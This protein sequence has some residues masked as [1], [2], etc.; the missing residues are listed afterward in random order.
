[1]QSP[2]LRKQPDISPDLRIRLTDAP[3]SFTVAFV[4]SRTSCGLKVLPS[5]VGVSRRPRARP[6]ER[7][8]SEAGAR[9]CL[10]KKNIVQM[11]IP[12]AE[13]AAASAE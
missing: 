5:A 2:D 13:A 12:T 8:R 4:L 10:Y 3:W 6:S 1:M 7:A 11:N 9:G